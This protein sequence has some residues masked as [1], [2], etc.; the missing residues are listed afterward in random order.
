MRDM[1]DIDLAQRIYGGRI[2]FCKTVVAKEKAGG[3]D[4]YLAVGSYILKVNVSHVSHVSHSTL[5]LKEA[6]TTEFWQLPGPS[7]ET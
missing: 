6:Y 3:F 2:T 4:F 7:I 1:R 5:K